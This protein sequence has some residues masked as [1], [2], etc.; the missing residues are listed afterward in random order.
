MKL[1]VS[2][3]WLLARNKNLPKGS[4]RVEE[5]DEE[6][7]KILLHARR[8]LFPWWR[9]GMC[10]CLWWP[11]ASISSSSSSSSCCWDARQFVFS[12][13]SHMSDSQEEFC[14]GN[15]SNPPRNRVHPRGRGAACRT[16]CLQARLIGP[17]KKTCFVTRPAQRL[18]TSL[19]AVPACVDCSVLYLYMQFFLLGLIY[20][21]LYATLHAQLIS[22][23]MN[24]MLLN[25]P[26]P[27]ES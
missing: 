13:C 3:V 21:T 1:L 20:F 10:P 14:V 17:V 5:G 24:C 9:G 18:L 6:E 19:A 8:C 25:A 23:Y 2:H 4:W 27:I 26:A 12:C 7:E 15:V 11:H 16:S 22:K